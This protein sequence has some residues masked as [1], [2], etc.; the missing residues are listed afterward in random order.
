MRLRQWWKYRHATVI[1]LR[2]GNAFLMPKGGSLTLEFEGVGG[3]GR[4]EVDTKF[5]KDST[6]EKTNEYLIHE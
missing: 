1:V 2:D 6:W 4:C 5:E 3:G